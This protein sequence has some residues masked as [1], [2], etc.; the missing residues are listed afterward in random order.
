MVWT[1]LAGETGRTSLVLPDGCMDL[2]WHGGRLLVAGPDT[3]AHAVTSPA[4]TTWTGLRFAPGQ[5]PAVLGVPA[6]ELR[7]RRVLLADLVTP[8]VLRAMTGAVEE[9]DDPGRALE[10]VALRHRRAAPDP[11]LAAAARLLGRG[12]G[13]EE[14]ADALGL[15]TRTLHRRCLAGFGY[16]PKVLARVLRLQAALRAA[17]A[18]RPA[19]LVAA[20][21]G[22]ADQAHLARDVRALT[23]T[24]LTRLLT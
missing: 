11:V 8:P 22:Y 15:G 23:G 24:T 12:R 2:L 17:R 1:A 4:G 7:D 5:A 18:G 6:V 3:A 16:G 9:S 19:A 14:V 21:A 20:E 10:D 13:V